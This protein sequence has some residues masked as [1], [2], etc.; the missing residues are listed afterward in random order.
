M[1]ETTTDTI[2]VV[3]HDTIKITN[4]NLSLFVGDN[5]VFVGGTWEYHATILFN[6]PTT[7]GIN[8]MVG[9]SIDIYKF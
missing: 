6:S 8:L 2:R 3:K 4:E 5:R 9:V 7:L 1:P